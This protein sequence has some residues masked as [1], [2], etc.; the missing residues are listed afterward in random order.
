MFEN[1][2]CLVNFVCIVLEQGVKM[3]TLSSMVKPNIGV[4]PSRGLVKD[5]ISK[6]CYISVP[7]VCFGID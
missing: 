5:V 4:Q 2:A 7:E 6:L 1:E 3:L